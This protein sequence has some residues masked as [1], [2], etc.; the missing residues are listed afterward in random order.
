MASDYTMS[1]SIV[2]NAHAEIRRLAVAGS[3]I[4]SGDNRVKRLALDIRKMGETVPVFA[5]L[6]DSI[7]SLVDPGAG[8]SAGKLLEAAA[9]ANAL[10][11]AQGVV[12]VEGELIVLGSSG[13]DLPIVS[14][15]WT[16]SGVKEAIGAC[17]VRRMRLF[18]KVCEGGE[19]VDLRL[20]DTFLGL[21]YDPSDDVANLVCRKILP[22]YGEIILPQLLS[23]YN[24]KGKVGDCRRLELIA[25][26][27]KE[28][29]KDMYLDSLKRGYAGVKV[30][31]LKCLRCVPVATDVVIKYSRSKN[32]NVRVTAFELLAG[33]GSEAA[34]DRIIEA[35]RNDEELYYVR[36]LSNHLI[37][38]DLKPQSELVRKLIEEWD[39]Y[40]SCYQQKKADQK[41]AE[42]LDAIL[43]M[44]HRSD[45]ARVQEFFEQCK[46]QPD[47]LARIAE[48]IERGIKKHGIDVEDPDDRK[49]L[50]SAIRSIIHSPGEYGTRGLS[51]LTCLAA[52]AAI[53]ENDREA[54]D[55][56][57]R[58]AS[59]P[60]SPIYDGFTDSIYHYTDRQL[61]KKADFLVTRRLFEMAMDIVTPHMSLFC[62]ALLVMRKDST[63]L[64]V[65]REMNEKFL[66]KCLP[67]GHINP[68]IYSNAACLYVE[69]GE[70]DK[71]LECIDLAKK[72]NYWGYNGMLKDIRMSPIFE[73]FRKDERAVK[74]LERYYL[75]TIES[76][77]RALESD[78]K[79]VY[80]WNN[81]G[82]YL[83][84]LGLYQEALECY[85]KAMELD[86][87]LESA[88]KAKEDL[89]QLIP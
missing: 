18:E 89:L 39:S 19:F 6:A 37:S 86:S 61:S 64:P 31:A 45:S 8:G 47:C 11:Y 63:G 57:V 41:M 10:L 5:R 80:A 14:S 73:D 40:L 2:N 26:I 23:G 48:L 78:S 7:D 36:A 54:V 70:Y 53:L 28:E 44:L 46:Q 38:D 83:R 77:D 59:D 9:L 71:A 52:H 35:L 69:M 4:A 15:Y 65:D 3:D 84:K 50:L 30:S 43:S 32:R 13:L 51:K 25:G 21:L 60:S 42:K 1:V 55:M 17:G 56:I 85:N 33:D 76:L 88:I 81:K 74:M 12:G 66:G 87:H 62:N 49:N 20:L 24:V 75:E 79:D 29:G 68:E 16:I 34:A 82:Y 67:Y 72:H 22:D 58:F 27:L